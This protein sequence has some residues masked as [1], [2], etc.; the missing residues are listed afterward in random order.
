MEHG[1]RLN[2]TVTDINDNGFQEILVKG[3]EQIL[4]YNFDGSLKTI[5]S[6]P[7]I[8]S[9]LDTEI[10]TADLNH[11]GNLEIIVKYY[12][13]SYFGAPEDQ[14]GEFVAVLDSQGNML[15]GWPQL[16]Y[17]YMY[18]GHSYSCGQLFAADSTVALGCFDD[19]LERRVVV[20]SPRNVFDEGFDPQDPWCDPD[21][22]TKPCWTCEGRVNAYNFDGSLVEGFPVDI[23]GVIFSSPA[24]GDINNDGYD[25]I[26]VGTLASRGPESGLYVI[27]RSGQVM[28]GWPKLL[29]ESVW[30][31]PA[32]GDV[33]NDGNLEILVTITLGPYAYRTYLLDYQ[34]NILS[35]WPR[36]IGQPG[37]RPVIGD[38][39][40][41]GMPN[42]VATGGYGLGGG[43]LG[44]AGVYA[45]NL[46]GT[47]VLGFPKV[48]DGAALAGAT[49]ADLSSN[50]KV[51]LVATSLYDYDYTVGRPKYRSTIYVWELGQDYNREAMEWPM[52][53]HDPQHTG[54]YGAT[55]L[56]TRVVSVDGAT[57]PPYH[58]TNPTPE[59][60]ISGEHDMRVRWA[61]QNMRYSEMSAEE[62][63]Q[64]DVVGSIAA[65]NLT[66]R[67]EREHTIYVAA[68]DAF[69]ND[70]ALHQNLEVTLILTIELVIDTTELPDGQV[71]VSYE[72]TLE[73][74][75]GTEPYTW[76]IVDGDLPPGL[77]LDAD[78]GVISGTPTE[79][80]TFDF[81]VEVTDAADATATRELSI[82]IIA[83]TEF[84]TDPVGDQFHGYGPDIVGVDFHLDD[85]T[86]RFRVRTAEP[87]DQHEVAN[88]M[89]FDLDLDPSTG[90]VSDDPDI[91]TNDI[92]VD[93][94]ALIVPA[95]L[96][97]AENSS[98]PVGTVGP[99][100]PLRTGHAH[101]SSAD[102]LGALLQW[103]P[104]VEDF[105]FVGYLVVF[106][107]T[108]SF[109]FAISLDMLDDDGIMGVV[110]L[111]GQIVGNDVEPT[112][113]APNEGHGIT[114][115]DPAPMWTVPM[116]ADAGP[117][118]SN[119]EL[120]FGIH[121]DATDGYDSGID[122]PSAPQGSGD[123]FDAYFSIIHP[124]FSRLNRDFRGEIPNQW[125]LEV[126]ST[127]EP[128]DLS[129]DATGVPAHLSAIMKYGTETI[130]MRVQDNVE[131]PAGTYVITIS[132]SDFSVSE[133]E[134]DPNP[135][136]V[137]H[138]TTFSVD[139]SGGVEPYTYLWEFGDGETSEEATPTHIYDEPDTYTVQVTVTDEMGNVQTCSFDLMVFPP[140]SIADC[141]ADPDPARVGYQ[142]G[143]SV[144]VTG[145]VGAYTYDWDFGDGNGSQS[146]APNHVYTT[147][148]TY[149]VSVTVT[150]LLS[151]T[152]NCD[153]DLVV[154]PP[155]EITTGLL[156]QGEVGD[157]Y[158]AELEAIGGA[159]PYIWE[160][161]GL[162]NGL[163]CSQGGVISGT[164]IGEVGEFIVTVTVSD[165]MANTDSRELSLTVSC[166][167][168]DANM[169]GVVNAGDLTKVRRIFFGIDA[170]TPCADVNGDGVV[171]AGDLTA[172]RMI[173]FGLMHT[174]G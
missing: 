30:A 113:V 70:Q 13:S 8:L 21:N 129:W 162:P 60:V 37:L 147:P 44:D 155:L 31:S 76:A 52:F 172:I 124:T 159:E 156:P 146:A 160:A 24:V 40:G 167:L 61:E 154:R 161:T 114:A 12:S 150:D 123:L 20:A 101:A 51:E 38:V 23:D 80:S 137:G 81:A 53:H 128:I 130:D 33:N 68:Q 151:N 66:Q 106:A 86:I 56:T 87:I 72:A 9:S 25:E 34:G 77:D 88:Y 170:P 152:Q 84:I 32:L 64:F 164:P 94:I 115:H 107:D 75:G 98:L 26:V 96:I 4:T 166:K 141:R 171:N 158:Y 3:K 5:I 165:A 132:V 140:L 117:E 105:S 69:G 95:Y 149:T 15:P 145:G 10:V 42:M 92:G 19:S 49:T 118:G 17:D 78:T 14:K 139:V 90:F 85:E 153:F 91:P 174:D 46:D 47:T 48:T 83:W 173:F 74:T 57:E 35:G 125:T 67:E 54:L 73:A 104:D 100:R 136:K 29:G 11:D 59:I 119:A 121:P 1:Y 63:Y 168:G 138:S 103:D 109:S 36:A 82:S 122:V 62:A 7:G 157:G 28:T 102:L 135:T 111:I 16:H 112:D 163:T 55:A 144:T 131:L 27:D 22:P 133:C 45:W 99:G 71:G 93:A 134:A 18:E 142:T 169:D 108:H 2:L 120:A 50:G 43:D 110:N 79:S 97:T 39:T 89:L 41:D 58:T 148:D 126:N 6:I 143:F 65:V 116:T 127:N